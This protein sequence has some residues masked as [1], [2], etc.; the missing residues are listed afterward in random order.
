M[1]RILLGLVEFFTVKYGQQKQID[2]GHFDKN[3][4]FGN[5]FSQKCQKLSG[6]TVKKCHKTAKNVKIYQNLLKIYQRLSKYGLLHMNCERY[7][8][9]NL[10]H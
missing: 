6:R 2:Y 9:R 5:H 10:I 3:K 1:C 4:G 7:I 8:F